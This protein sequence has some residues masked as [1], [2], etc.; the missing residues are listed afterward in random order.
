[1]GQPLHTTAHDAAPQAC[2]GAQ[3]LI[4]L[5]VSSRGLRPN[6]QQNQT[7]QHSTDVGDT[8]VEGLELLLVGSNSHHSLQDEYIEHSNEHTVCHHKESNKEAI[9]K[10]DCVV[11]AGKLHDILM[12][13]VRVRK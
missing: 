1:M 3:A 11:R 10:V 8:G 13:T 4:Q 12:E 9:E 7:L 2:P 5:H 6:H